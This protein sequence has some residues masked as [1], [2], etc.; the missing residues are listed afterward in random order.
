MATIADL[1]AKSQL[2]AGTHSLRL[3]K[4]VHDSAESAYRPEKNQKDNGRIAILFG[5]NEHEGLASESVMPEQLDWVLPI[6]ISKLG[7][8]V[9]FDMTTDF[10]SDFAMR[11]SIVE[12]L[13]GAVGEYFDMVVEEAN[14][15][16]VNG[17]KLF[18]CTFA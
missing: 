4:A 8:S 12:S 17:T 5:S 1:I 14:L 9:S 7:N 10:D 6:W 11:E 13:N 2:S 3:V 18:N 15:P 16:P